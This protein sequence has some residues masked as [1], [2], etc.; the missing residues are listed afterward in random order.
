MVIYSYRKGKQPKTTKFGG[1]HNGSIRNRKGKSNGKQ[2][3]LERKEPKSQRRSSLGLMRTTNTNWRL[4]TSTGWTTRNSPH[5]LR[6][7]QKAL[8]RQMPKV[9]TRFAGKSTASTF[10]EKEI[11]DDALF[12]EEYENACEFEWVTPTGWGDVPKGQGTGTC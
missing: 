7:T 4:K 12:D 3:G 2:N 5:G 8:Q 11:D 10:T 1:K 9:S 6:K